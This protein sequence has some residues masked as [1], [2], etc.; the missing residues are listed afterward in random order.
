MNYTHVGGY[1]GLC[2][3]NSKSQWE[4]L[5]PVDAGEIKSPISQDNEYKATELFLFQ[6]AF[7]SDATLSVRDM[8]A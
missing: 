5:T 4:H 8:T 6:R 7:D 3:F 2:I 1:V